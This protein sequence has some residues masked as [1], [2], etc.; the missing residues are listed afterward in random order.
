M[1]TWPYFGTLNLWFI[2]QVIDAK[3]IYVLVACTNV[4]ILSPQVTDAK[5]I[6]CLP[7]Q[8]PFILVVG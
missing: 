2:G 8:L 5:A 1:A 4:A 7:H 6:I 3:S